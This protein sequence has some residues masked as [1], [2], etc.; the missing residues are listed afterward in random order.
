[1]YE[2]FPYFHNP[3]KTVRALMNQNTNENQSLANDI[4]IVDDNPNNLLI[5]HGLL[6]NLNYNI[7]SVNTGKQA[8]SAM[9]VNVPDLVLLDIIMPGMDGFDVIK[10]MKKQKHLKNVP[11]I[12]VT[13]LTDMNNKKKGFKLGA[14]DYITKPYDD[15]EV[16]A[17]VNI[18]MTIQNAKKALE[19]KNQELKNAHNTLKQLNEKL[20]ES[21]HDRTLEIQESN[22]CFKESEDRFKAFVEDTHSLVTQVDNKGVILYANHT[23]Q[24]IV[25]LQPDTCVGE[26]AF[27]F[28]HEDDKVST[29]Q[30]S[31]KCVQG[32]IS[33]STV[34][35][36]Q[37]NY[38]TGKSFDISWTVHFYYDAEGNVLYANSIGHDITKQKREEKIQDIQLRLF[39][40]DSKV[41]LKKLLQRF[42]D[43]TE[44]LT[45][46]TISFYYFSDNNQESPELQVWSTN[47]MQYFNKTP[48][49]VSLY[50]ADLWT[51]CIHKN[52]PIIDNNIS[53][54]KGE[55]EGVTRGLVVPVVRNKKIVAVMGFVNKHINYDNDDIQVVK[56]MAE[57]AL[58]MT[59]RIMAQK[60]LQASEK[61]FRSYIEH[62][63]IVIFILNEWGVILEVN[64]ATIQNTDYSREELINT[65]INDYVYQEDMHLAEEHAINLV[66]QGGASNTIRIIHKNKEIHYWLV[67]SVKL[68]EKKFLM[69]ANDITENIQYENF[70]HQYEKMEAV[71]QLASGIAHDF[72]NQ[73]T[74]IIGFAQMLLYQTNNPEIKDYASKIV[75]GLTHSSDL[76]RKLLTFS[77]KDSQP[78]TLVDLHG[79][80]HEVISLLK[81]SIDK[82][83]DLHQDLN[84]KISTIIGCPGQLQNA[85]LNLGI[86]ARD[87]MPDGGK[88]IFSTQNIELDENFCKKHLDIIASGDYLLL[89]VI[90]SGTGI[91][92]K[93]LKHIFEP[94]YTTKMKGKG[95]G[96]GL[97]S[98]YATV[99][100]HKGLITVDSE[101]N[102]GATFNLYF[103]LVSCEHTNVSAN[104]LTQEAVPGNGHI[105][106]VEDVEIVC[107]I[108]PKI[109]ENLGYSVSICRN[110]YIALDFYKK[111]WKTIDLVILDMVMPV[112]DGKTT[113]IKMREINPDVF[114]L[115]SSGLDV[116]KDV[117]WTIEHGAKGFIPKPYSKGELSQIISN[118]LKS[119]KK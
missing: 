26:N 29:R 74:G 28:I 38:K 48:H 82:K 84:A 89:K 20:E 114:V 92:E 81:H 96:L 59:I 16:R 9:N 5:L 39:E 55:L 64:N 107:Q 104:P 113:F 73:L 87:A 54:V 35:N 118:A 119:K 60:D 46:S 37:M 108:V 12:F 41:P 80:I 14:V 25:G 40:S 106:F 49:A 102:K 45:E 44:S 7:R 3:I 101:P 67:K 66:E 57:M 116:N 21:V 86:N 15:L 4:L 50:L 98:V 103:P 95:T 94:F 13:V 47:T 63:P 34:E 2:L 112:M 6:S 1:M 100:N 32:Q 109:L 93:T 27:S 85:F 111:H 56:R 8:L 88:L 79:I 76:S 65:L 77:R 18:H 83:I 71:G 62:A 31:E 22:Q 10:Q 70:L 91:D 61:K 58:E 97:A 52:L 19:S 51:E 99:K 36:R 43:E 33:N 115:I 69:F 23:F 53:Q 42:L 11:V 72:N 117:E 68:S 30:W 17:R 24:K 75:A 90:D 78:E 105:L 110:G